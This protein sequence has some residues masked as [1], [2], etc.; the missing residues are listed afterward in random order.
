[1]AAAV[2]R[3]TVAITFGVDIDTEADAVGVVTVSNVMHI[4]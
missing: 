4:T 1:V 2:F 3:V